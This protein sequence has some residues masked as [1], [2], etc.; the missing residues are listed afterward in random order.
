MKI[1]VCTQFN[2]PFKEVADITLP[3][4][5]EYCSRHGYYLRVDEDAPIIRSIVWDRFVILSEEMAKQECDWIVHFDAD[6]LVTNLHIRLEEFLDRDLVISKVVR[7]DGAE[8]LNDGVMLVRNNASTI[9]LMRQIFTTP[10]TE[11][12]QCG[13]DVL[14]EMINLDPHAPWLKIERHK[15]INSFLYAEYGMPE[16]TVGN[17][18]AG[19]FVLHLPGR[20]N[21]RR[22]ELFTEYSKHILR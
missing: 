11:K 4:L 3:V 19:D 17:W 12:I 13:Q 18:T 22:A 15:A 9:P 8:V 1:V 20:T 16:T 7:E 6:I 21:T 10:S 5:S 2:A 14:Q